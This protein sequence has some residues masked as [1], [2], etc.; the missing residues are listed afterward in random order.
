LKTKEKKIRKTKEREKK[1]GYEAV[2][3]KSIKEK[4]LAAISREQAFNPHPY[5][6]SIIA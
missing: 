1:E 2:W 4:E 5:T 6:D 3:R